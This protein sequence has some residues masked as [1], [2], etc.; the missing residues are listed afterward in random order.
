MTNLAVKA[1]SQYQSADNSSIAYADPHELILRLMN[2]AIER[3]A[4]A[5]GAMQRGNPGERGEY[6]GKAISIIGGLEGC[7]DHSQQGTLS[8]NLSDLYQ[9]MIVTLT[10][11]N[12]ADD[13]VKLNEVSALMLEIKSAWEQIPAQLQKSGA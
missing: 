13:I 11:A 5:R 3:I 12:V 2:G 10:Q 8:A 6:L 9:Y 7:L 1:V 4:Q